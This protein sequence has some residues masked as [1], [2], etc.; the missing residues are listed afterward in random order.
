MGC[1]GTRSPIVPSETSAAGARGVAAKHQR[2]GAGPERVGERL[3]VGRRVRRAR[4]SSR[5]VRDEELRPSCR[6]TSASAAKIVATRSGSG[7]RHSP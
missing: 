7:R 2:Q 5:G 4:S 3:R 6:R 1:A